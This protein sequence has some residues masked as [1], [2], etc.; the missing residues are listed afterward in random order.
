VQFL[1]AAHDI[2]TK[3]NAFQLCGNELRV[4][5]DGRGSQHFHDIQE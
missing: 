1:A 3:R 2:R 4:H 5:V